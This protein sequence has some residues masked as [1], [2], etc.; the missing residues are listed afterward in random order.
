MA[1]VGMRNLMS[2]A[3]ALVKLCVLTIYVPELRTQSLACTLPCRDNV[4][5]WCR[6]FVDTQVVVVVVWK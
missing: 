6:C 3:E 4:L 1:T 5:F 2:N